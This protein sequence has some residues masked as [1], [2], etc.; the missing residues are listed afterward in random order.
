MRPQLVITSGTGW[1][2]PTVQLDPSFIVMRKPG[3][4]SWQ[5]PGPTWT[6][7][8]SLSLPVKNNVICSFARSRLSAP[9]TEWVQEGRIEIQKKKQKE[10]HIVPDPSKS[11]EW[12]GK[13]WVICG[14]RS[15]IGGQCSPQS[16]LTRPDYAYQASTALPLP[17]SRLIA[18]RWL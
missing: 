3:L 12:A 6:L 10:Q 5:W 8:L 18:W 11:S 15:R 14:S 7:P 1:G 13:G 9:W 2:P 17:G 4:E 16:C